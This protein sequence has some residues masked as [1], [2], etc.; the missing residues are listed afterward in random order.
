MSLTTAYGKLL[1]LSRWNCDSRTDNIHHIQWA[2]VADV[3]EI[4]FKPCNCVFLKI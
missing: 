3:T 2:V 1:T 4:G